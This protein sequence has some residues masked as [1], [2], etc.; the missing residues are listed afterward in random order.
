[1]QKLI[2]ALAI[3]AALGTQPVHSA[4]PD[5]TPVL[6]HYAGLVHANYEDTLNA[7]RAMQQAIH[8]FLANPSADTQ[9]AAQK[10]WRAA[11]EFYGQTEAFRFYGGPIDDD[12]GPEGRLNAWPMDE[13][14]VD[15]VAGDATAG[16][17]NDRGFAITKEAVAERNEK[18]G[19]EN[20]ATGW[21]AIEFLLWGQDLSETGA[22]ARPHTDFVDG[23][24][25]NA[26][27]RRQYLSVITELLID[28]LDS[29]VKAW[30][31]GSKLNYR[32]QFVAGGLESL[33]K[34]FVA[35]GSLS[36]GELAGERLEVALNSQDQEDEHSCFSDNTHRD[37]VLNATGIE[38]VWLG[39]Y[40]RADGS[41]LQGAS[42]R[43]LVAAQD[44][45]LADRTSR[46]LAAS[47]AA[48][49]AIQ[50]PFDREIVGGRDAPGRQ[51]IQATVNSLVQ[52]SKD[53]VAAANAVGISKLTLVQP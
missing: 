46:Q 22:G 18:D 34:M 9:Q 32:T 35:M 44:A 29:L 17:I 27:R 1:M 24:A 48:A 3:T 42:P 36:R 6:S 31:P 8:A 39:R 10:A 26:D 19:E 2:L 51:R 38:N 40:K 4:E 16:L 47:V 21:H 7:A 15:G 45:A 12:D 33:R 49:S 5:V 52:Q 28:D 43:D 25:P 41:V 50:A 53:L 11:R 20:I 30:R 23:Q 37:A 13:S 14:Y